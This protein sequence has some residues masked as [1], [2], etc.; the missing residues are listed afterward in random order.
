MNDYRTI[1]TVLQNSTPL[2]PSA[3]APAIVTVSTVG[4][5]VA[6]IWRKTRWF[7]IV[8]VYVLL[9]FMAA[10]LDG[11]GVRGM[12]ARAK[13]SYLKGDYAVVEG[14][15]S[16]FH[17]MPYSGHEEETFFVNGLRFSY[18][19]YELGPCFNN[20]ASHGGPIR[21]GLRIRIAFR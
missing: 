17:P 15:V 6:L 14:T 11:S 18:S 1:F 2:W 7:V 21:E 19:D 9:L 10:V 13:D 8:P 20:T 12:Y 4:A 3:I 5:V 16:N